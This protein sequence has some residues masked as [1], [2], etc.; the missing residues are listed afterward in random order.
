M[1]GALISTSVSTFCNLLTAGSIKLVWNAPATANGTAIRAPIVG[2]ISLAASHASIAPI[3][4]WE[5]D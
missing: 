2:A 3:S 5:I 1:R 4:K